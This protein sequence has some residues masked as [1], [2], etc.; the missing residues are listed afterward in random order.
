MCLGGVVQGGAGWSAVVVWR[1]RER[2][3]QWCG[4]S[5]VA[6]AGLGGGEASAGEEEAKGKEEGE[7]GEVEV[8]ETQVAG[9]DNRASVCGCA[10]DWSFYKGEALVMLRKLAP[11]L[12]LVVVV[13]GGVCVSPAFA[14]QSGS[15]WW[16][17][18]SLAWP[19]NLPAGGSGKIVVMAQNRGDVSVDGGLDPV[20]VRDVLPASLKATAAEGM[21]GTHNMSLS[22]FRGVLK[23]SLPTVHEVVCTFENNAK[24]EAEILPPYEQLEVQ[25]TVGVGEAASSG[26]VNTVSVSGGGARE[27]SVSRPISV[28]EE[29]V[30][31]VENTES[32][33]EEEGGAISTQAGKHPFQLTDVLQLNTSVLSTNIVNQEPAALAKDLVFQL[34]P[35]L[36]GNPAAVPQCSDAHFAKDVPGVPHNECP[37]D[38]A[39]G[40]ATVMFNAPGSGGGYQSRTVP[41]FNLAPQPGEPAR[42][43]FEPSG[44]RIYLDTAVRTGGDYG[45]T[46]SVSNL[47]QIDGFFASK[48]TFWGVPGEPAHDNARGWACVLDEPGC[49]PLGD[50]EPAPFL[51]LPT[52]CTGAMPTSVQVDSWAEPHPANPKR[53]PL[54]SEYEM[55]G[56][57]GCNH[58]QLA[59][60][61]SVAP[62]IPNASTPTGLEVLVHVPQTAALNPEGLAESALRNT[63][64]A[65][66]VGVGVNPGGADGLEACSESEVGYRGKMPGEP[67]E[68]LFTPVLGSPFCPNASKIGTVE[69]ET[70]LLAHTIKGAAYLATQDENPF[71]S[72][73]ALYLVAEDPVSGTLIKLTGEVSL[74]EGTGQL[75]T[76]FKDTPELPFENLRLHFFGESRAPLGTPALCG[77]YTTSATFAPWSGND[78]SN[79]GSTFN[80]TSGPNGSPCPNPPGDQ[81]PSTLPFSPSLTAGSTNIQAG[82]FTPFTMTMSREDGNQDLKGISLHM[83]AGLSGTLVGVALCGEAQ[84]DAGTCGPESLIGETTVSVGLGGNP[85]TVTGGKVYL[86]GPY[87]GAPFGLSIVNPANAGPFHLGSVIVRARIEVDPNTTQLTITSD[88]TGP[89]A[90]PPMID[91]IPLQIKHINVT[92]NRPGGFTFNPTNCTPS[93]ITGALTSIHGATSSLS[94]PFQATNCATLQFAPKFTVSTSGQTSKANGASLNVKLLYPQAAF[95]SQANIKQVKVDLPK[96]LPS[97][98]TTLQQACVA[99]VFEANPA[100]CPAASLIG[101]ATATTP[102]LPVPLSGPAYFVSHGGEAFPSLIIVL[103]GYGVTLDLIGS[104]FISKQGITSSTFKTVPDAPVGSFELNLPEG[105]YSALTANGSLCSPTKVVTVKQ[106]VKVQSHGHRKTVTRNVK[107][108][109]IETLAMPT[110]FVAQNGAVI[111]QSTP[112][113]VTGCPKTAKAKQAKA[114]KHG[115]THKGG[116]G[117]TRR[118]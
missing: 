13:V 113:A 28:G 49:V 34:P 104:T 12:A 41:L 63:T 99:K 86:T 72:L 106:R 59:P 85:Y 25:I 62:D 24:G 38:T 9:Q 89:Y 46:V 101:H 87:E 83:P 80:I 14:G 107:K 71:G 61:I 22:N 117:T 82:A 51:S 67:A 3:V 105:K 21:A 65:L 37:P 118:G 5:R 33:A 68:N 116:K 31:G 74:T 10:W 78:A 108:T 30:F 93:A 7:E 57:D 69:I 23:C 103:Q 73:I 112:I 18:S 66:P 91:G 45:V 115:K 53:A 26:E 92:V 58:L 32:L 75:V 76:T 114:K 100:G 1:P 95:G 90:I 52:A 98:L 36:I 60:Q 4:E 2:D 79:T 111:H 15:V 97:R 70:P 55:G 84:A 56:L 6:R 94:V 54:F 109:G 39:I 77:S 20:V 35:G 29:T 27:V 48:V 81:S 19:S 42:F 88:T 102:L 50:A 8:N 96:Q 11:F 16:G 110:E 40:V 44:A 43:G 64:V 17:V 47:V